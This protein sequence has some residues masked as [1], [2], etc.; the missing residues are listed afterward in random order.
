M[1]NKIKINSNLIYVVRN[2]LDKN[3]FVYAT[4]NNDIIIIHFEDYEEVTAVLD[5]ANIEYE[6][7][8][9]YAE[10]E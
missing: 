6:Y 1:F 2:L 10:T 9:E 3:H 8:G 7:L 4:E 5:S